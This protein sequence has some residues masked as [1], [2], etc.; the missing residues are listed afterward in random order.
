[1]I[2]GASGPQAARVVSQSLQLQE[3]S[4]TSLSLG[5]PQPLQLK[6][7]QAREGDGL[8][9]AASAVRIEVQS[10]LWVALYQIDQE[11]FQLELALRTAASA[12]DMPLRSSTV[13]PLRL[14]TWSTIAESDDPKQAA[15][16]HYVLQARL[17]AQ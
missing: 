7:L 17:S 3:G 15:S 12:G 5:N 4:K 14:G 9:T 1:M 11:Q 10:G 6:T 16:Q 13:V 2:G 8:E